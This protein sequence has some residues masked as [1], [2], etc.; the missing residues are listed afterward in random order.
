[1]FLKKLKRR[2]N[3]KDHVY[4]ALMESYRT[5]RGPRHRAVAYLGELDVADCGGWDRRLWMLDR[6]MVNEDNLTF[7]RERGGK[8][9]VGAPQELWKTYIQ[10][11]DAEAAFR[12][13][14]SELCLRP[15]YHQL[16]HRVHAHILVAFLACAM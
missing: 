13:I 5:P 14:K 8:Y 15:V 1:V 2:K 4:W 12:T 7:I 10:L 6:G 16:E 3:G 9:I 11:A